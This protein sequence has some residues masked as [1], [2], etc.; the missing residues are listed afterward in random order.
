MPAFVLQTLDLDESGK[1]LRFVIGKE[2][3]D[4]ALA[5]TELRAGSQEG[6]LAVH[7]QRNGID[8]LVRGR[9][10]ASLTAVCARC[11]AEVPLDVE[12]TW[13]TLFSPA[14]LRADE[15]DEVEVDVQDISRDYYAGREVVLDSVVREYLLL[16]V[17][18]KPLC[19]ADCKGIAVPEHIRPP[20]E[21]FGKS[22]LDAR[23]APLLKLKEALDE[24][25]E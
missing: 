15:A 16:E 14:H 7:A 6:S 10:A 25:K 12:T 3:L 21:V 4:A 24:R 9:L 22:A 1:D 18:M 20:E 13:T 19:S 17:P 11:L 8:V 2:W 23:L 5:D